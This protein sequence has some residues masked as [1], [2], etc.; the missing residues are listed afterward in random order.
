PGDLVRVFVDEE[1]RPAQLLAA[2]SVVEGT[3]ERAEGQSLQLSDGRVIQLLDTAEILDA[4][5]KPASPDTLGPGARLRA[6]VN[7]TT[8]HSGQV[9]VLQPAAGR[10][11]ARIQ[12]VGILDPRPAYT[13]GSV[14]RVRLLGTPGGSAAF[15]VAGV[16]SSVPMREVAAGR[17]EGTAELRVPQGQEKRAALTGSL[18]VG[19][20]TV[21]RSLPQPILI[22]GKPPTLS[23]PSPA[24]DTAVEGLRP[25]ISAAFRD[26]GSGVDLDTVRMSLDD[27]DV[28]RQLT[29]TSSRCSLQPE[30]DLAP[31]AHRVVVQAADKAG[32]AATLRWTFRIATG[33]ARKIVSVAHNAQDPLAAGEVLRVTVVT[34][35]PGNRCWA[36]VGGLTIN[37]NRQQAAQ[38][39]RVVYAG[40]YT[41]RPNDKVVRGKLV[42]HFAD[43]NGR[44]E[45]MD[46]S[47]PVTLRGDWPSGVRITSPAENA[48][49]TGEFRVE[50]V[51]K[52]GATIRVIV[53]YR[54]ERILAFQGEVA[55]FTVKAD[56]T[57]KWQTDPIDPKIPL[58]GMADTYTISAELLD[59]DQVKAREQRTVK[60][61]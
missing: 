40:S 2:Y 55:R 20:R 9:T 6:R 36:T 30:N 58:I 26:D 1:G 46:A 24:P 49:I 8:M 52:P 47:T 15:T 13:P 14:I 17:Y 50:G 28:T 33:P 57:G 23:D 4:A 29:L 22:D 60:R 53:T 37:L 48:T 43:A 3:V 56:E 44:E 41:V 25:T 32:N 35:E 21:T 51:A 39:N 61:G 11:E 18:T 27:R 10:E 12:A 38:P 31:G 59:G 19:A 7:P 42:A 34:T 54:K 45:T 5:G 16:V